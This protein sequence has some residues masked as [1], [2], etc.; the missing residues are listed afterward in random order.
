MTPSTSPFSPGDKVVAY[1]RYSEGD[2]QGLKNTSTEEQA[3]AIRRFCDDNGLTI[4]QI[5]ADPFASG[6]SVRG[7]DHYLEMLSFLLHKK[8]TDIAG[9]VLWDYERYGRNYDQ[10]TLDAAR[11]RMAGY[12]IYSLQ[13]PITDSSP[14]AKVVEAMYM[15]SAQNQSDMISADVRRA[16]Q[17]NFQKYKV[18]PRSCIPDG[19]IAVPVN[20]GTFS[21]GRPR[22]GYKAEPD[23]EFAQKIR[24]AIDQRFQ[25]ATLEEMKM[26]I[27]GI[28]VS[29]P[30]EMVRRLMLKPLLYGQMTYGGATIEDYCV[31]IIDKDTWDRLQL[32][33]RYAPKE[34]VKP[35]GHYS[36]NRPL[37]S[38]LLYC[39]VCGKKAFL[40]RRRA[41]GRLYETYYCND[42]HVGFR[43]Q[44]LDDFIISKGIELLADDEYK[45][46]V[47]AIAEA[48][49]TPF[50][51]KADNSTITAEIAKID[52]KIARISSAI[53]ESDEPSATLVKRLAELE[54]QRALLSENLHTTDDADA[55]ADI[56]AEADRL[57]LSIIEVLNSEKSSTDDLRTALSLFIHSIVIYPEGKI[58]IRH[59][60]PGMAS[61]AST[62][63]GDVSAPPRA[64]STYSQPTETY[65]ITPVPRA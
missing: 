60:L 24:Q 11:L 6:R 21:D 9:V 32:Y 35:Q 8:R 37:L 45:H 57:R 3:E 12:K 10:A 47:E 64:V 48:L 20:M 59:T 27:G 40:D 65:Y 31:P 28:Y 44:M 46:T 53:E 2:E 26:I 30:R 7:R 62:T 50:I 19:W 36:K 34:H 18:I 39:G 43:R 42:K 14:F 54:K 63:S 25:G 23:P 61:V 5:F 17:N 15:A 56:L 13:Q 41:K 52:R 16:L 4:V 38:G 49:K 51:E 29:K 1:C 22:I 58:L 33:N 55:G